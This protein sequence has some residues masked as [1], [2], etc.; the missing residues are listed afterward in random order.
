MRSLGDSEAD[1]CVERLKPGNGDLSFRNVGKSD[2][3]YRMLSRSDRAI[4]RPAASWSH[5]FRLQ[6]QP[7]HA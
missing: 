7:G 1:A 4:L 2:V 6:W 3:A 5:M